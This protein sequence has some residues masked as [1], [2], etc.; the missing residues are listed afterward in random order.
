MRKENRSLE[1]FVD[2]ML[3]LK[4]FMM[5]SHTLHIALK[6]SEGYQEFIKWEHEYLAD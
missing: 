1:F 3:P 6:D 4:N 5:L 2:R